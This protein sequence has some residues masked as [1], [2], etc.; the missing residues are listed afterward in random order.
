MKQYDFTF[1]GKLSVDGAEETLLD[2][3]CEE[4]DSNVKD[5]K[6]SEL[7]NEFYINVVVELENGI[8]LDCEISWEE[9]EWKATVWQFD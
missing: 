7:S 2:K 1:K 3:V 6:T 9:T 8:E 4:L 5:T